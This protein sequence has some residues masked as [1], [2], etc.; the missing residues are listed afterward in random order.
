MSENAV[1]HSLASAC[2]HCGED[3][4]KHPVA[5]DGKHFCC[6]GC[7]MVYSILNEND[8]C[9]YY[10]LNEAAGVSLKGR[11]EAKYTFLD[12]EDAK[13]K[14]IDF[15]DG[16][17]TKVHFILPQ[18]HCSSCLWL[19]E[20][21]ARL[22]EGIT[23]SR[24]NFLKKE[25][26]LQYDERL[27]SLRQVVE[28]LASIGYAPIINL[29]KLG[30]DK[31][32]VVDKSLYYKLGLAGFAF[33]NIMLL[34]FP[35]YLGLDPSVDGA[36]ARFFGYL[37]IGLV[38]PVVWYS[39]SDYLQS[40]WQG[41]RQ[42]HLNI[43]VPVSLGILALFGRSVYEILSHTGA[44][45]LDSLSGLIFFLLVGKWFQQKTYYK[46]SF[47]RDYKSYFPIAANLIE[48]GVEKPITID[49]LKPGD[50]IRVRHGELI[51]ADAILMKG[52]GFIDYSFVTGESD[53]QSKSK[54]DQIYA[55]GRQKGG[56]I[57]LSV[58]KKVANSYLTQ[59]WNDDAFA[60][61]S[62]KGEASELADKVATYFTWA[63]LAIGFATLI[64]WL[65]KDKE[66]AFQ[67]FTAVLI[68]ACPCAVALSIPFTFGNALR[69]L[70][71][72][73]FY[74]KN[75][76]VIELLS[77]VDHIVFDKTGTITK[78][79]GSVLTYEGEKL[80]PEE[81]VWIKSLVAQSAHPV[82]RWIEESIT[83]TM[84]EQVNDFNEKIGEGISGVIN[85]H[86]LKVGST[87]WIKGLLTG[88]NNFNQGTYVQID[89][90]IRGYYKKEGSYREGLTSNLISLKKK[91]SLSLLTGDHEKEKIN[92]ENL[93]GK[94]ANTYFNQSP[95]QKLEYVKKLQH[96]RQKVMMIGDG[97]N[98]AGALK[99][100]DV[101]I[102]ITESS[103]NF[104]P[105]CD[106]IL[107]ASRFKS[108]PDFVEFGKRSIKLVYLAYLIALIYNIVGMSYAVQGLLSP[109]IAAILMPASSISIVLFGMGSSTLLAK[110]MGILSSI[111]N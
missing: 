57:E 37:N 78:S 15:T 11:K 96:N 76:H 64:Y 95:E 82:S 107:E 109:V 83:G 30:N 81:K 92:I 34:S 94:D 61:K 20:N 52:D 12:Q 98:D 84:V 70:G 55:G 4:G 13:L 36:F 8:L 39:G 110:K 105:A 28:L 54:G 9:N 91:Y 7:K 62:Q 73:K 18:I 22:N 56:A 74:L 100:S 66:V 85:G 51:P 50:V 103:N 17:W 19:L 44:G 79:N 71:N 65:P 38:L 59:L 26:H 47:E 80:K 14:I 99:Q 63:V 89:N 48:E 75:T 1:N 60:K 43:D 102:V 106:A 97:L 35:E 69:I 93:F 68:I 90:R 29:D 49:K 21:L 41:I 27:T 24:V 86:K 46:L 16:E 101:G 3:N 33:G 6:Q 32:K 111:T 72:S 45:Y 58:I 108:L 25:I 77:K 31:D 23:Q 67:S 40:A 87:K 104:T 5:F 53:P 42:R 88:E 2:Y 10:T